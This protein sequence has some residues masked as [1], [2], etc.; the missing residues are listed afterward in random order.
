MQSAARKMFNATIKGKAD[1]CLPI[2]KTLLEG[3]IAK[4]SPS[5]SGR[6]LREYERVR[7]EFSPK[8]EGRHVYIGF[9]NNI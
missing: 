6:D 4:K 3:V 1:E 9:Y 5:V 8:D 7:S 2:S